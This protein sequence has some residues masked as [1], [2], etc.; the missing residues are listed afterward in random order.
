MPWFVDVRYALC[1]I[2]VCS[3]RVAQMQ[4]AGK[5]VYSTG[6]TP[7]DVAQIKSGGASIGELTGLSCTE[8]FYKNSVTKYLILNSCENLQFGVIDISSSPSAILLTLC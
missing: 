1:I 3:K 7:E 8:S 2:V 5:S 4:A 6:V